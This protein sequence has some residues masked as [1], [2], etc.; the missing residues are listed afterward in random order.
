MSYLHGGSEHDTFSTLEA[1]GVSFDAQ[2]V[3]SI[4]AG[5][6]HEPANTRRA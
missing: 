3:I 4:A 2:G 6:E 5:S 1:L